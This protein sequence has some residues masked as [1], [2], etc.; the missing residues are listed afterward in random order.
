MFISTCETLGRKYLSAATTFNITRIITET[1]ALRETLINV[2]IIFFFHQHLF[3]ETQI[4]AENKQPRI[5]PQP[6]GGY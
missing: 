6:R 1:P 2:S 3:R 5:H 4:Q